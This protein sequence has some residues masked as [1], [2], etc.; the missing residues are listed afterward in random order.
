MPDGPGNATVN[1]FEVNAAGATT[2]TRSPAARRCRPATR[3]AG[4]RY[5]D[6]NTTA[7]FGE[8]VTLCLA[9]DPAR[10]PT[11]AVRLLQSDGS[12]VDRRHD[13]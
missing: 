3:R 8:P 9:Y 4:A 2:S 1:F 10:Y 11:S 7:E 13:D 5:Y 12:H 6:I